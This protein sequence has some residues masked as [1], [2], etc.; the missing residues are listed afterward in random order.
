[1]LADLRH[2]HA[3]GEQPDLRQHHPLA[4]GHGR[5]QAVGVVRLDADHLDLRAQVL[6]VGGDARHQAAAA[7]RHEDGVQRAAVLAEDFHGHGALPGDHVRVVIGRHEGQALLRRQLQRVGQG[8]GE[9]IAVQH[10][11]AATGTHAVDL[12]LRGGARHHD[13]R[14]DAQLPRRQRQALG[15]VAGRCGDHAPRALFRAQLHHTVVGTTDLEG[16]DRLQVLALEQHLVAQP[17]AELAGGLQG[18]FDGHVVHWRGEDLA[19]VVLEQA[20]APIQRA[21]GE[22]VGGS[23]GEGGHAGL[24]VLIF[25]PRRQKE[26]T[27]LEGGFLFGRRLTR[28]CWNGGNNRGAGQPRGLSHGGQSS[29][30]MAFRSSSNF[31]QYQWKN[32]AGQRSGDVIAHH[33]QLGGVLVHAPDHTEQLF[34]QR[35]ITDSVSRA[36][37]REGGGLVVHGHGVQGLAEVSEVTSHTKGLCQIWNQLIE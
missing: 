8:V 35:R 15:M 12:E 34:F 36:H 25:S 9:G 21:L 31:I 32:R 7:N 30:T 4:G 22:G 26:E 14:F 28:H 10:H 29:G 16:V 6:H 33:A 24:L 27:R 18:R 11:L 2:R 1:M 19:H 3:V 37:H 17:L 20:F 13:G 23:G 5:L